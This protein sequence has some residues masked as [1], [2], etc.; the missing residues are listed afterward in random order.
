MPGMPGIPGMGGMGAGCVEAGG[1]A[2]GLGGV[3]LAG[4]RKVGTCV[5]VGA[6]AGV[7]VDVD[8]AGIDLPGMLGMPGMFGMVVEPAAEGGAAGAGLPVPMSIPG[9]LMAM[10]CMAAIRFVSESMRNCAEVTTRSPSASPE[11]TG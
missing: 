3:E 8:A 2:G 9:M 5:G 7:G 11:I 6:G 1:G 4:E 10:F